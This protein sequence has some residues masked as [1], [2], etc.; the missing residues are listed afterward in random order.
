M[1]W[2]NEGK[3]DF[4]MSSFETNGTPRCEAGVGAFTVWDASR[5]EEDQDLH[6]PRR[7]DDRERHVGRRSPRCE[8][9][10]R[11][12]AALVRGAPELPRRWHRRGRLLRPRHSL[13]ATS[14]TKGRSREEGYFLPWRGSTSAA[15]WVTDEIVYTIDYERGFDILRYTGKL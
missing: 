4:I 13:P 8:R 9:S 6:D 12:L 11:L 10:A 15:Y 7:V 2:P 5:L 1:V 14:T 3:D